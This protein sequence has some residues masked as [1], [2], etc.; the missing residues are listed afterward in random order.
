MSLKDV[1]DGK[2]DDFLDKLGIKWF[3]DFFE[4]YEQIRRQKKFVGFD[5]M[6]WETYFL[7]REQFNVLNTYRECVQF[8]IG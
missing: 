1:Q 6:L 4:T 8:Y 2:I 5:D 7:L 3:P